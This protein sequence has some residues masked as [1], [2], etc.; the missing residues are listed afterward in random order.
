MNS[1]RKPDC[2][3]FLGLAY[4]SDAGKADG[5]LNP[6]IY[7]ILLSWNIARQLWRLISTVLPEY[8]FQFNFFF[9]K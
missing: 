6:E 7:F 9:F 8:K 1:H 3:A 5:T 4:C 2:R